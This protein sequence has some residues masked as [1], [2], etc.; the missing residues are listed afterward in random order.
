MEKHPAEFI[1]K[2]ARKIKAF[3]EGIETKFNTPED[4]SKLPKMNYDL[5]SN[6]NN[7]QRK[8]VDN[9][10]SSEAKP[11][12]KNNFEVKERLVNS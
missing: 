7:S 2:Y 3:M 12:C 5:Q 10:I 11:A 1:K 9:A 8:D 4:A 6:V